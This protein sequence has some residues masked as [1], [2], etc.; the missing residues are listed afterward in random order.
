MSVFCNISVA[1]KPGVVS[2]KVFTQ[3]NIYLGE[4]NILY[5]SKD[6]QKRVLQRIVWYKRLQRF[7]FQ[8][9]AHSHGNVEQ[10]TFGLASSSSD[11]K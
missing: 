10:N 8:E 9:F 4:T 1:E 6:K 7:L 2:V 11:G 3:D 5:L